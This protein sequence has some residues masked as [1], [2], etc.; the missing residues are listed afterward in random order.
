M[1]RLLR[2]RDARLRTSAGSLAEQS[3][4]SPDD[5]GCRTEER[6]GTINS[7]Q[8]KMSTG[9]HY[10]TLEVDAGT[11]PAVDGSLESSG[12]I[13]FASDILD[14]S[15]CGDRRS[16]DTRSFNLRDLATGIFGSKI[17]PQD[18]RIST[19]E[20]RLGSPAGAAGY[21]NQRTKAVQRVH[22]IDF[23][24]AEEPDSR[25]V[26]DATEDAARAAIP[27]RSGSR[28]NACADLQGNYVRQNIEGDL[29][30]DRGTTAAKEQLGG[31]VTGKPNVKKCY[32]SRGEHNQMPA[33]CRIKVRFMLGYP[34]GMHLA[35]AAYPSASK[36]LPTVSPQLTNLSTV[37]L[38][39]V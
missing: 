19:P 23:S 1:N 11:N 22:E 4:V 20:K 18:T 26:E 16:E 32:N 29:Y 2:E 7:G 31:S 15:S 14:E 30:G 35:L 34:G 25:S 21:P 8:A 37:R 10:S 24:K 13:F 39:T 33:E 9:N 17:V 5:M 27:S 28:D 6:S 36:T 3:A 12:E 38:A